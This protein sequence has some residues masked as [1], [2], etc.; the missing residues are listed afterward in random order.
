MS[1][2][3][4][5]D[6]AGLYAAHVAER[7]RT[8]GRALEE[9]NFD[10]LLVHSGTPFTYFADDNDAPFHPTPHFAHWAPV[11]GPGHL[12]EF[13]PGKRARLLRVTPRDYWYEP[14]APAPEFVRESFEVV[15]LASPELAWDG[16][17]ANGRTA[18]VGGAP[19][20]ASARGF[21][22]AAVNPPALVARL[23]W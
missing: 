15:D 4:T 19:E 17:G 21:A 7:A 1:G 9:T 5:P 14:P 13:V 2:M 3:S 23:D 10:R 22:A 8:T 12:L 16:V 18:Y 6:L 20:E 11:E